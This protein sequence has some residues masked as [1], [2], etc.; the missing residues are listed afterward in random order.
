MTYY[1]AILLCIVM[2]I[3]AALLWHQKKRVRHSEVDLLHRLLANHN[4]PVLAKATIIRIDYAH[5]SFKTIEEWL[6]LHPT[7]R[8]QSLI[9]L[10]H[11]P[12]WLCNIKR[13]TWGAR[14][15]VLDAT[16]CHPAWD[17]LV[18]SGYTVAEWSD[19]RIRRFT[20]QQLYLNHFTPHPSPSK[21]EVIET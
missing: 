21:Q 4:I 10:L 16:Q 3:V 1:A 5:S 9:I 13:K 20:D 15:T 7:E 14:A 11:A 6:S 18:R 2:A 17:M 12:E 19:N 8:D